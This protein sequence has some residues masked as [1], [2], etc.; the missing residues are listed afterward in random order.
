[1]PQNTHV[2]SFLEMLAVERG[3]NETT[4][5]IYRRILQ[6]LAAFLGSRGRALEDAQAEDRLCI[7]GPRWTAIAP[8]GACPRLGPMEMPGG[9]LCLRTL[10]S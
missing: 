8:D 1:M 7:S 6:A 3:V 10:F 4:R 2:E 5:R 9:E